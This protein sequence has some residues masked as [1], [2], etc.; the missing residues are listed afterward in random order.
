MQLAKLPLRLLR[1]EFRDPDSGQGSLLG[2]RS[3]VGTV[4]EDVEVTLGELVDTGMFTPGGFVG[5]LFDATGVGDG[6]VDC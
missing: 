4:A 5:D 6:G 1:R 2:T 3:G